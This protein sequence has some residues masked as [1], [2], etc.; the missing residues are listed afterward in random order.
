MAGRASE[1]FRNSIIIKAQL[2]ARDRSLESGPAHHDRN[3]ESEAENDSREQEEETLSNMTPDE[4]TY[5]P[6]GPDEDHKEKEDA[7]QGP[8]EGWNQP[9]PDGTSHH[10]L[11]D[12]GFRGRVKHDHHR[13]ADAAS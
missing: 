7:K 3:N 6:N 2:H 11:D 10:E 9:P 12:G 8:E 4:P 13:S 1:N 5:C